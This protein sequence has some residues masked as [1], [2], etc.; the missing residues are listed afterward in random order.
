MRGV[1]GGFQDGTPAGGTVVR[2]YFLNAVM[3]ELIALLQLFDAQPLSTGDDAA[4]H[5]QLATLFAQYLCRAQQ[6]YPD[7]APNLSVLIDPAA[8]LLGEWPFRVRQNGQWVTPPMPDFG[9]ETI[10]PVIP[11]TPPLTDQTHGSRGGQDLHASATAQQAGFLSA[12]GFQALTELASTKPSIHRTSWA[13]VGPGEQLVVPH[14]LV[15][16]PSLIEL[17]YKSATFGPVPIRHFFNAQ[18]QFVGASIWEVTDSTIKIAI[19]DHLW[20]GYT[21]QGL[22]LFTSGQIQVVAIAFGA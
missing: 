16:A 18:H 15:V 1:P 14:P 5:H 21:D 4:D 12:E 20:E 10:A 13:T 8:L 7:S 11:V 19:G 17:W 3:G 9:S 6:T 22:Q 2:A